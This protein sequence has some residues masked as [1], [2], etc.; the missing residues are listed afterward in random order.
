MMFLGHLALVVAAAFTG[1]ATTRL[2][3]AQT[4]EFNLDSLRNATPMTT[5]GIGS[6][7]GMASP[8]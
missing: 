2:G 6:R 5:S 1:A 4:C 7:P 8:R 3:A